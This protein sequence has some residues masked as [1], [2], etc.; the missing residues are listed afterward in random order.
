MASVVSGSAPPR[1]AT[2]VGVGKHALWLT[3]GVH[4]YFKFLFP[5]I[6]Y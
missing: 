6:R 4:F 2:P 1:N 5:A 3:H